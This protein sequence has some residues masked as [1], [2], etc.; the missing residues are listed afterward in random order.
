MRPDGDVERGPRLM[1]AE[2]L[3][4]K[5]S[6]PSVTRAMTWLSRPIDHSSSANEARNAWAT[7]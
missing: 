5:A 2:R 7:P 6:P 4:K 1:F 3:A